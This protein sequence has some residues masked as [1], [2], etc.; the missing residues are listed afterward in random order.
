MNVEIPGQGKVI[1]FYGKEAQ[2]LVHC[3]ELAEMIQA[4]TKIHRIGCGPDV[5]PDAYENLVEEV[6]DCLI[7]FQQLIE[8]YGIPDHEL[9]RMIDYKC[10]RQEARMDA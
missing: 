8:I 5:P 9:Q 2:M 7:C 10:V 6:A 1:G 3:G 4:I